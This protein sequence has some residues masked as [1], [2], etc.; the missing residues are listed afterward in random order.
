MKIRRIKKIREAFRKNPD[1]RDANAGARVFTI[2][3]SSKGRPRSKETNCTMEKG[4]MAIYANMRPGDEE[5]IYQK[6]I[7]LIEKVETTLKK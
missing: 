4:E 3:P 2:M 1:I 7:N 6:A 5:N